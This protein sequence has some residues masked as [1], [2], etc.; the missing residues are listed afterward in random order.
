LNTAAV[1]FS[2]KYFARNTT[3]IEVDD[4]LLRENGNEYGE[5]D[6]LVGERNNLTSPSKVHL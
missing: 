6:F 5:N 3:L 4:I 1:C 2:K